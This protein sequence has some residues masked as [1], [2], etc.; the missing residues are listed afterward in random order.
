VALVL[1]VAVVVGILRGGSHYLYCPYMDVVVAEDCCSEARGLVKGSTIEAPDCCEARSIGALPSAAGTSTA[2]TVA[3]ASQ[4][5]VLPAVQALAHC[6]APAHVA[7]SDRPL[8]G[9]PPLEN[10]ERA[11]RLMV[12]LI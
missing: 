7:S 12:F 1:G 8:T 4:V 9:P 6:I 2:P 11:A 10:A 3:A 5:A